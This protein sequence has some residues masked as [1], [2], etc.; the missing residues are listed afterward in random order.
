MG[1]MSQAV[2]WWAGTLNLEPVYQFVTNRINTF[3]LVYLSLI[4]AGTLDL[5]LE[6]Q[7]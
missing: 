4:Y 7:P 5:V 1:R 3:R 6:A 2:T